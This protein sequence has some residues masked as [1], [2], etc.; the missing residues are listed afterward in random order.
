[1]EEEVGLRW[2]R[3]RWRRRRRWKKRRLGLRCKEN[4]GGSRRGATVSRQETGPKNPHRS[5]SLT[6]CPAQ[7]K[8]GDTL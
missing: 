5:R 8:A 2:R 6:G 1:M 7:H 4:R 3:R